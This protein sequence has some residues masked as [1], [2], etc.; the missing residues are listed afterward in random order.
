MSTRNVIGIWHGGDGV[1]VADA[2]LTF[3]LTKKGGFDATGLYGTVPIEVATGVDGAFVAELYPNTDSLDATRWQVIFPDGAVRFFDLPAG[4]GDVAL[5]TLLA[6]AVE[7]PPEVTVE[8]FQ[9]LVDAHNEDPDAHPNL[10]GA[11]GPPGA[12][13]KTILSGTGAPSNSVGANGDYFLD[14]TN[15]RLYGPKTSGAWG[16]YVSLIGP[17]GIQGIQGPQGD[18]ATNLVTS[19]FTRQGAV[20]G[21][22]GDYPYN[23]R[24]VV[25]ATDTLQL[26]DNQ[27]YVD[28]NRGAGV[29]VTLPNSFPVGWVCEV[30][31]IGAGQVTFATA[32]GATLRNRSGHTKTAGQYAPVLLRVISNSG[33]SAAEYL[34]TGDTA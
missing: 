31:Q 4:G 2:V 9:G 13:G 20:S 23:G 5:Y 18:P 7:P 34:L 27:R 30:T 6:A 8:A 32:S 1:P 28:V 25:N 17:Q 19:V 29:T 12:D 10:Q 22:D 15:S 24:I 14:T 3:K 33:G 26:T 21:V 11:Q 16:G